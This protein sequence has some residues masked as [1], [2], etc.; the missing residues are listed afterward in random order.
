MKNLKTKFIGLLL[1]AV[2][3]LTFN[4]VNGSPMEHVS[5]G[6]VPSLAFAA[7]AKTELIER[8]L[9]NKFR[10]ESTWLTQVPSKNQWVN[11][12]VIKLNQIGADPTVLVDN[13]SYPITI[14]ARTDES[15]PISLFKY[16]TTNTKITDD[17]LYAL[18]YDKIGSVQRQHRETLEETTSW[19]ALWNLAPAEDTTNTPILETTG[20]AIGG[21]GTRKRLTSAD[22]ITMK[23]KLD[24]L[25]IPAQ[26][27]VL[28]LNAE[29]VADLLLEDK[30]FTTQYQNHT[31]GMIAKMYYGFEIYEHQNEVKYDGSGDKLAFK[32]A[33]SGRNASVI[34]H[35]KTTAKARG[36]VS[37]YSALSKDD[38]TN[39]QTVLGMRLWFLCVPTQTKGQS[40]I[41][42]GIA[43]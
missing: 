1:F 5:D 41:I 38:P 9:I 37:A 29:H 24:A 4:A 40:A 7:V 2:A 33:T 8:E 22:L 31:N 27:R 13:T 11:N 35:K 21:S 16:D 15:T 10:H 14:T 6:T 18:P 42:D 36:S 17:E 32:S 34:F 28:V 25:L 39:R 30:A 20:A 3:F 19:H 26:G 43:A 12:D 23:K